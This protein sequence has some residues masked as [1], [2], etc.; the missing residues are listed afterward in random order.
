MWEFAH[1]A[2]AARLTANKKAGRC[3]CC[4]TARLPKPTWG[5][6]QQEWTKDFVGIYSHK[7]ELQKQPQPN[8][9]V[10]T[11]SSAPRQAQN[12]KAAYCTQTIIR[13]ISSIM[14]SG[15]YDSECFTGGKQGKDGLNDL[16]DNEADRVMSKP[17][18]AAKMDWNTMFL[19]AL[20]TLPSQSNIPLP[21][22]E[23]AKRLS[24][25]SKWDFPTKSA[26]DF[27][28]PRTKAQA[29]KPAKIPKTVVSETKRCTGKNYWSDCLCDRCGGANVSWTCWRAK[30]AAWLEAETLNTSWI[31]N[32]P[33]ANLN[34][35]K[36][37]SQDVSRHYCPRRLCRGWL[38][39]SH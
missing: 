34:T 39:A 13:N 6:S 23:T 10:T 9:H 26:L 25:T 31:S 12:R 24:P 17:H 7:S 38:I 18:C 3:E 28:I 1:Y 27:E 15:G 19:D 33:T 11:I 35:F 14:T 29:N 16:I 32:P 21:R 8:T 36:V 22:L 5:V 2:C 37:S 30:K 20:C 4:M